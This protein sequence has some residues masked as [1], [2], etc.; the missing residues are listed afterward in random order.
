MTRKNFSHYISFCAILSALIMFLVFRD[1]ISDTVRDSLI[2][3]YKKVI[4]PLFPYM[5]IASLIVSSDLFRPVYRFIPSE[6][7]FGLPRSCVS[8]LLS[9][10]ICGFPVGAVGTCRLFEN[11]SITKAEAAKLCAIS[12]SVSP[13]F[14]IGCIGEIWNC[15]AYGVFLYLCGIAVS[16]TAAV[17]LIPRGKLDEHDVSFVRKTRAAP[18]IESLCKA[19][20]DAAQSCITITAF[21]TFFKCLATLFSTIIPPLSHIITG[22][23]EFSSGA[24]GGAGL[25]GIRGAILSGFSVGFSGLS[26]MMQTYSFTAKHGISLGKMFVLSIVKGAVL[27][28]LS[29]F[30]YFLHPIKSESETMTL[31]ENL[32]QSGL[33]GQFGRN[34]MLF[35]TIALFVSIIICNICR[36]R[37]YFRERY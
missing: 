25:G 7:L 30:F 21:I 17:L 24:I 1:I 10:L 35:I 9:G 22:V 31:A 34:E 11:G 23:L 32:T 26:V 4:P 37:N 18:L 19:I 12:S 5:V 13:S 8:V 6:R 3:A 2:M 28:S 36:I 27:A 29:A 16:M 14:L 33:N 15:P 20:S